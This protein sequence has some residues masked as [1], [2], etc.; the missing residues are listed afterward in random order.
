MME[1]CE[2]TTEKYVYQGLQEFGDVL[3]Y[4]VTE[5]PYEYGKPFNVKVE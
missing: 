2:C 1:T 5:E 4:F 3:G